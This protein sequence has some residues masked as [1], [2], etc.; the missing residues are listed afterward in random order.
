MGQQLWLSHAA[1][2]ADALLEA[3]GG[4][5][6]LAV[7]TLST[8]WL[9]SLLGVT[10]SAEQKCLYAADNGDENWLW[11]VVFG[12]SPPVRVSTGS[13]ATLELG[14]QPCV[15]WLWGQTNAFRLVLYRDQ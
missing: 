8:D 7:T 9:E 5:L 4:A 14:G 2:G 15:A 3:E 1:E 11:D 10:V 13:A 6:L 12:T